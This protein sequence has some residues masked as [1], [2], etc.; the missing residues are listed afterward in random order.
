MH[1]VVPGSAAPLVI[2]GAGAATLT[3]VTGPPP[4]MPRSYRSFSRLNL[5]LSASFIFLYLSF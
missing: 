1:L 2:C 4:E 3:V 5:S